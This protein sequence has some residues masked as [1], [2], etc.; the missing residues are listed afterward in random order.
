MLK[1]IAMDRCNPQ[2]QKL[3]RVLRIYESGEGAPGTRIGEVYSPFSHLTLNSRD[4]TV[5][6]FPQCVCRGTWLGGGKGNNIDLEVRA[7]TCSS[8]PGMGWGLCI[9]R[10]PSASIRGFLCSPLLG[11]R[12]TWSSALPRLIYDPP[13]GTVESLGDGW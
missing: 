11:P 7:P 12:S 3:F 4:I 2:K 6:G 1:M 9:G 5:L 10:R 8:T 13:E